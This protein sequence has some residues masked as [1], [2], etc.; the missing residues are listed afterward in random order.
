VNA[1]PENLRAQGQ[2][3]VD[4][5]LLAPLVVRHLQGD[6][7]IGGR[8]V[9]LSAARAQSYGGNF[10]GSLD[11]QLAAVPS[12]RI[13]LDY[14]HI[15]V[16]AFAAPISSLDNL[17]AGSASGGLTFSFHGT[18]RADLISS[19]ECRGHAS[20]TD[21]Q[22]GALNLTESLR[23]GEAVPGSSSF[24]EASAEFVCHEGKVAFQRLAFVGPNQEI[25]GSG[26]VDF[27]RNLDLRLRA[28][29]ASEDDIPTTASTRSAAN[30]TFILTGPLE[31]PTIK[32]VPQTPSEP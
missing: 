22:L 23:R 20:I 26:A 12:Y 7:K 8:H 29:S 16:S 6:L 2:I 25:A 9:Q 30:G 15:D 13:D 18:D 31:A 19:V 32:P 17:F 3:T 4:Q 14:S 24:S 27:G 28:L 11:A 21:A 10:E 1:V 5:F